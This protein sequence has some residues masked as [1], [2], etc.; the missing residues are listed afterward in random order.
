MNFMAPA[1]GRLKLSAD[2]LADKPDRSAVG[3]LRRS[4]CPPNPRRY[5]GCK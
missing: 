4:L 5:R 3:G 1:F 2:R